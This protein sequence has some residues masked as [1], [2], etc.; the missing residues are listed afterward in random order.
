MT[1]RK[2][3]WITPVTLALCALLSSCSGGAGS[4][5]ASADAE[6]TPEAS[7]SFDLGSVSPK[8]E[9]NLETSTVTLPSD[10]VETGGA[11]DY[12]ILDAYTA[13]RAVC[14][15]EKLGLNPAVSRSSVSPESL[16]FD[17]WGP[18]TEDMASRFGFA[19]P[20]ST[21]S[22]IRNGIIPGADTSHDGQPGIVPGSYIYDDDST[23][24]CDG[25]T[26]GQNKA[27]DEAC[28]DDPDVERFNEY[29]S[30]GNSPA[31]GELADTYETAMTDSQMKAL[32]AELSACYSENGMQMD[33]NRPGYVTASDTTTLNETQIQLAFQ[34][35]A[36]K[37]S[38]NFTQRA[39]DICAS[40]QIPVIEKYASE[41]FADR[42]AWDEHK[43][44]ATEYLAAQFGAI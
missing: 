17:W 43:A 16:M 26:V 33:P 20:Q 28:S 10:A 8:A 23:V 37:D 21:T 34:T 36:C 38:I 2:S 30:V 35:V 42:Q 27:I 5:D 44:E 40:Y 25:T 15:R 19:D 22:L 18:W 13:A 32:L 24:L 11:Y 4:G 41:L 39:A 1:M 14:A 9:L 7:V 31:S 29:S 6:S 12:T 3:L